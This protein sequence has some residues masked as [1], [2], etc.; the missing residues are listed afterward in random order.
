[1]VSFSDDEMDSSKVKNKDAKIRF[2]EKICD[3]VGDRLGVTVDLKPS[4]VV[5][6]LETE[7][8]CHFLQLFALVVELSK[9]TNNASNEVDSPSRQP[10]GKSVG[11][12]PN[13]SKERDVND[14]VSKELPLGRVDEEKEPKDNSQQE[15]MKEEASGNFIK[16]IRDEKSD[17]KDFSDETQHKRSETTPRPNSSKNVMPTDDNDIKGQDLFSTECNEEETFTEIEE[18][19]DQD[20]NESKH[21]MPDVLPSTLDLDSG[22]PEHKENVVEELEGGKTSIEHLFFGTDEFQE[23]TIVDEAKQSIRPKTARRRPPRIK[24]RT[25]SAEKKSTIKVERPVIFK[26]DDDGEG[27]V[28]DQENSSNTK[29]IEKSDHDRC[30]SMKIFCLSLIFLLLQ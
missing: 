28:I 7:K 13:E 9:Q 30:V 22:P 27:D 5:A 17:I 24:E 4:K 18:K 29:K 3:Y 19:R 20:Q 16:T 14:S 6:G 1:M 12:M 21:D 10:E 2:L 15:E 11:D 23:E 25:Q 8:T 26:D